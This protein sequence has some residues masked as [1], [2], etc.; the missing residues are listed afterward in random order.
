[1]VRAFYDSYGNVWYVTSILSREI[2][3]IFSRCL[4]PLRIPAHVASLSWTT[5]ASTTVKK[6]RHWWKTCTVSKFVTVH[7]TLLTCLSV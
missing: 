1:M 3:D 6:S 7:Y 4:T 5:V 2:T